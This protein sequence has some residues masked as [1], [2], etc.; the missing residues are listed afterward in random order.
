MNDYD[1]S[2]EYALIDEAEMTFREI[3]AALTTTPAAIIGG[4]ATT[5]AHRSGPTG[6]LGGPGRRSV[7]ERSSV[8]RRALYVEGRSGDLP[9]ARSGLGTTRLEA[10]SSIW[11]ARAGSIVDVVTQNRPGATPKTVLGSGKLDEVYW[12]STVS[13]AVEELVRKPRA[14]HEAP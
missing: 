2:D 1:P 6:G 3:L 12:L 11:A 10:P 4:A 14:L 9:V 13:D 5:R 7:S 8:R